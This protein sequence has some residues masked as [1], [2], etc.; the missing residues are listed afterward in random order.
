M[1]AASSTGVPAPPPAG[2]VEVLKRIKTTE[3]EWAEKVAAARTAADAELDRRRSDRDAAVKDATEAADA[4]RA[5]A[6]DRARADIDREYAA[7][8]ADGEV[9]AATAARTTGKT[10][11]D[12]RDQVLAAVLGPFAGSD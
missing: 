12:R 2:S 5:G 6:L 3:A 1:A 4:D 11:F 9:S 8:L 10:P 7:I